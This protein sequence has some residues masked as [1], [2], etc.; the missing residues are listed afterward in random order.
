MKMCSIFLYLFLSVFALGQTQPQPATALTPRVL[1][2]TLGSEDVTVIHLRSGYVSSIRLPEEV[3]SIVVGDP[4]GFAAEHSE[5]EPRLVF[6]KPVMSRS[7]ET[8]AL[9]TTK[10][11]HEVVLQLISDGKSQGGQVDFLLDYGRPRSFLVP[12]SASIFNVGETRSISA[13]GSP[14]TALNGNAHLSRPELVRQLRVVVPKWQGKELQVA[15]GEVN[16]NGSKMTITFSVRNGSDSAVELLPPQVQL[17][18]PS[19]QRGSKTKAELI[20]VEDYSLTFRHLQPGARADGVLV[21][22]RPAFKESSEQL[23]LQIA[24]AAQVDRPVLIP[25][26]FTAPME[27]SAR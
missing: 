2:L 24:Q 21:F 16:Q 10:S 26:S 15:L 23:L 13:E 19:K 6:L 7:G 20:A 14:P 12:P 9:I 25:F 27:G 18:G 4:K 3:S 5:A 8:N 1:S 17:C 22:E 11:G